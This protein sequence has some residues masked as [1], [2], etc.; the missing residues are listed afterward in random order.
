MGYCKQCGE[1][2]REPSGVC[3]PCG[4]KAVDAV[5]SGLSA[6]DNR[7]DIYSNAYLSSGLNAGVEKGLRKM[8]GDENTSVNEICI[9]CGRKLTKHEDVF[10]GPTHAGEHVYC[11]ACYGKHFKKGDCE[12][13]RRPVLGLGKEYVSQEGRIWHKECFDAGKSCAECFKVIFGQGVEALNKYYHPSCF[14]CFNC[15]SVIDGSFLD[16]NGE[17]CCRP[18]HEKIKSAR[19]SAAVKATPTPAP[20]TVPVD[21][22]SAAL[23]EFAERKDVPDLHVRCDKCFEVVRHGG[24]Q[25]PTGQLLHEACFT[26]S[27]CGKGINGKYIVDEGKIWHPECRVLVVSANS[28]LQC[29]RCGKPVSGR[30]VKLDGSVCHS[31]DFSALPAPHVKPHSLDGPLGI[32]RPGQPASLALRRAVQEPSHQVSPSIKR[33]LKNCAAPGA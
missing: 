26:C 31:E 8:L 12:K 25:L 22:N 7:G 9:E 3:A 11:E 10:V 16:F 1:I 4:T 17:P 23:K 29:I 15:H 14:K 19:P 20:K 18:C 2:V 28:N 13:C 5:D 24:I 27:E 30:F 21:D 32:R 6:K 33:A